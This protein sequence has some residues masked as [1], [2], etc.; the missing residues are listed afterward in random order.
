[1]S[2]PQDAGLLAASI[3]IQ[4]NGQ[5]Q[6]IAAG[7]SIDELLSALGL[8]PAQV[9]VEHNGLIVPRKARSSVCLQS[10]DRLELVTFVGGG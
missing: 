5:A 3:P 4:I 2:Q 1:M 9:A 7:Q 8:D 10:G 6:T